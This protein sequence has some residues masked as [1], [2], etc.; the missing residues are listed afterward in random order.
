M[1]QGDYKK[2]KVGLLMDHFNDDEN[3]QEVNRW[4]GKNDG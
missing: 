3:I 1:N 4:V 2:F